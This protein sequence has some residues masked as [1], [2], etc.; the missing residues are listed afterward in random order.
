ML[1]G[2]HWLLLII[3][4]KFFIETF[5]ITSCWEAIKTSTLWR[6]LME[7]GRMFDENKHFAKRFVNSRVAIFIGIH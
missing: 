3:F 7:W 1:D 6:I 4:L 2:Y 5:A